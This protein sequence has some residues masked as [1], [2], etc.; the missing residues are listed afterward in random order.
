[1]T[2]HEQF[3]IESAVKLLKN[4]VKFSA[5][6]GQKHLDLSICIAEERPRYQR[7]LMFLNLEIEKGQLKKEELEEML[8]L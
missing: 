4:I 6:E 7:A 8:G 1:M 2:N 3:T 5:V